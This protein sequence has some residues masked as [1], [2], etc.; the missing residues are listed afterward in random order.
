MWPHRPNFLM[1][2][3]Q[4]VSSKGAWRGHGEVRGGQNSCA[5]FFG[6]FVNFVWPSKLASTPPW[7]VFLIQTIEGNCI[8]FY[9]L[10]KLANIPQ[11]KKV[12]KHTPQIGGLLLSFLGAIMIIFLR[13]PSLIS[14][15]AAVIII[16]SPPPSLSTLFA[17]IIIILSRRQRNTVTP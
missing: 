14:F 12:G 1:P 3:N 5:K 6:M 17:S 11:G 13:R 10:A 16:L 7:Y 8:C 4:F 9:S 15:P 2:A